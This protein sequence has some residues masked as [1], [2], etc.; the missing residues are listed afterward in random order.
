VNLYESVAGRRHDEGILRESGLYEQ[1]QEKLGSFVN[2]QRFKIYGDSAYPLRNLILRPYTQ[3]A[4]TPGQENINNSMKS[5]RQSA[6][7]GFGKIVME[8]AI[9]DLKKKQK[10]MLQD[11]EKMYKAAVILSNCHTCLYGSQTSQY[12]ASLQLEDYLNVI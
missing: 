8:F 7:W 12:F 3:R 6:E 1:T 2:G 9:L 11:L 5:V 4:L 10:L